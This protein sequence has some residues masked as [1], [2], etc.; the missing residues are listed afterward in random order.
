MRT[1]SHA[2]SLYRDDMPQAR[3]D[4]IMRATDRPRDL[5]HLIKKYIGREASCELVLDHLSASRRHARLELVDGGS[6][7][8]V[9]ADS[10]NGTFL[11]RNGNWIRV[12]KVMLCVGDRI[13]F[14]DC[15]MPLQQLTALFGKRANVSLGA[16]H[17]SLRHGSKGT[18]TDTAWDQPGP[19]L[20]KPRRNPLT[21]KIEEDRF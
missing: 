1:A 11:N 4:V 5:T 17:F 15:E 8:V 9:D 21:G 12:R 19:S 14:G 7:W 16:K 3:R 10:R 6:V 18:K 20:H 2:R 13:R